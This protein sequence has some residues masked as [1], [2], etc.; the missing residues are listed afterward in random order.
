MYCSMVYGTMLYNNVLYFFVLDCFV[1]YGENCRTQYSTV[2]MK[3]TVQY[4]VVVYC[5]IHYSTVI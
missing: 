4:S 5:N 2:I 3:Y 1:M